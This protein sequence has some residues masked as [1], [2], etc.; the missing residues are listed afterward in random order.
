MSKEPIDT[1]PKLKEMDEALKHFKLEFGN[2]QHIQLAQAMK[3]MGLMRRELKI[4]KQAM[5]GARALEEDIVQLAAQ[6]LFLIKDPKHVI[7]PAREES[8]DASREVFGDAD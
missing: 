6:V 5:K 2:P 4:K 8:S 3:K 7:E 1:E